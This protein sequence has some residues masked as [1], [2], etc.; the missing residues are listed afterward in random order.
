MGDHVRGVVNARASGV[1]TDVE[2]SFEVLTRLLVSGAHQQ[3]LVDPQHV[4][5]SER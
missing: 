2:L 5:A 1:E 3:L 4:L